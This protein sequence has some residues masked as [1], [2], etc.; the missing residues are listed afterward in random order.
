MLSEYISE[1]GHDPRSTVLGHVQRGGSP[2]C[3][4]RLLGTRFGAAAVDFLM[5]GNTGIMVGV[6][7]SDIIA[8]TLEEVLSGK[9]EMNP[10]V[11]RL[12]E[13]LAH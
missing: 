13:P 5:N 10:E 7:A 3:Y 1:T 8:V 2:T 9:A 4:D 11:V 6:K 12:T